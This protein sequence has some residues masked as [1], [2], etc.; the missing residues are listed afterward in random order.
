MNAFCSERVKSGAE[1]LLMTDAKAKAE[2]LRNLDFVLGVEFL[3][4]DLVQFFGDGSVTLST[5]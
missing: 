4:L 1:L 3:T 2:F 5:A